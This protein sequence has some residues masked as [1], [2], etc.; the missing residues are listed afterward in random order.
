MEEDGLIPIS[1]AMRDRIV[2]IHLAKK[3]EFYCAQ[4]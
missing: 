4:K 3:G 2:P 1:M